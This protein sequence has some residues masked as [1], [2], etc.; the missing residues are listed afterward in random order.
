MA[1]MKT[2]KQEVLGEYVMD[3][4]LD[5]YSGSYFMRFVNDKGFITKKL[6]V[7]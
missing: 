6:I 1:R 3:G 2:A 4:N 5:L 7:K